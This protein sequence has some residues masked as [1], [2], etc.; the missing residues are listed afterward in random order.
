MI[1]EPLQ[2]EILSRI[3]KL[4]DQLGVTVEYLCPQLVR[5]T[6]IEGV[7][8]ILAM[9]VTVVIA[10]ALWIKTGNT[11][12]YDNEGWVIATGVATVVAAIFVIVVIGY[13]IPALLAPEAVTLKGLLP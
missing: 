5:L 13:S 2:Q 3:D 7:T 9:I 11:D 1:Q 8:C 6:V 12:S 10:G 4:A